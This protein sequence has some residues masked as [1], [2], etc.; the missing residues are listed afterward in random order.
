M[1]NSLKKISLVLLVALLSIGLAACG[2]GSGSGKDE[3]GEKAEKIILKYGDAVSTA[4]PQYEASV[5]FAQ[6]VAE[7]TDGRVEV[8][9][10]PN[11][12]LGNQREMTEGLKLG[13]IEIVKNTNAVFTGFV[14][15]TKVLDLPYLFT[16]TE[17][18]RRV[19]D[20]EVG[21]QLKAAAE[22]AGYKILWFFTPRARSVYNSQK[23]IYTPADISGMKIRVMESPI[24]IDTINTMGASAVPLAFGEVY[25]AL[26]Q[27]IVDGAENSIISYYA[28]KHSEVAKYFSETNTFY[29]PELVIMSLDKFNS[30]PEDVQKVFEELAGQVV[31][32]EHEVYQ[33]L[34]AKTK[35][36]LI[37][38]GSQ[39]NE[40]DIAPFREKMQPLYQKHANDVGGM[41]LINK[42]LNY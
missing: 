15:A 6:K 35:D 14:P 10:Y 34:E 33:E 5:F 12:Q 11:S 23:P 42:I 9:I 28:M 8:Q 17:H 20:G 30:L 36:I 41:D 18:A 13:T 22:E 3:Q 37:A 29:S 27:G 39:F 26:E 21:D 16:D 24:M 40:V 4:D 25:S 38:E 19:L 7:M 32:Y 1:L 2:G 31:A